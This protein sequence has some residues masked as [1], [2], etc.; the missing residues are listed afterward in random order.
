MSDP[1]AMTVVA[2]VGCGLFATVARD[3]VPESPRA[4]T[5]ARRLFAATFENT[6]LNPALERA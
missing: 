4:M 3:F 1:R 6:G 2:P 5:R